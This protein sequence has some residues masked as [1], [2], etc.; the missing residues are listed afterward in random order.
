MTRSEIYIY[1]LLEWS[2]QVAMKFFY[3]C[4]LVIL[5]HQL[6]LYYVPHCASQQKIKGGIKWKKIGKNNL[7]VLRVAGA[8]GIR[9]KKRT[10]GSY[11]SMIMNRY[12][13]IVKMRKKN[14]RISRICPGR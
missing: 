9:S 5:D 2:R 12:V 7:P 8:A 3:Q 1:T 4:F 14:V 13:W 10:A 6:K 11:R